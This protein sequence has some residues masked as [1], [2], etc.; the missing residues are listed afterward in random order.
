MNNYED[1]FQICFLC[2]KT[3]FGFFSWGVRCQLCKQQICSK[4]STKVR[5]VCKFAIIHYIFTFKLSSPMT[6]YFR[7]WGFRWSTSRGSRSPRFRGH[8][9]PGS[10]HRRRTRRTRTRSRRWGRLRRRQRCGV[11]TRDWRIGRLTWQILSPNFVGSF[12]L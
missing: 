9:R 7:R 11:E 10:L 12:F 3:R 8:L 1:P 4:C 6:Y 2:M 5:R